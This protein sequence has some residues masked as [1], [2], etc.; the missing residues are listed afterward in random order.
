MGASNSLGIQMRTIPTSNRLLCI[1]QARAIAIAAMIIAHFAPGVVERL[2]M[3][4]LL[5]DFILSLGRIAT[6]GFAAIFGVTVGLVYLPKFLGAGGGAATKGLL[7]RAFMVTTCAFL[8]AIPRYA[9]QWPVPRMFNVSNLYSSYSVLLF[10]AIALLTMPIWLK[11]IARS[12]RAVSLTLAIISYMMV[13]IVR[14][15]AWPPSTDKDALEFV[16]LVFFSGKYA[17]FLMMGTTFLF[18]PI[19][20]YLHALTQ[21]RPVPAIPAAIGVLAGSVFVCSLVAP[22]FWVEDINEFV[23]Y[24]N[25]RTL[26]VWYHIA[27]GNLALLMIVAFDRL[28]RNSALWDVASHPLAV[29]GKQALPIYTAHAFILPSLHL[30]DRVYKIEGPLRAILPLLLFATICLL[31]VNR[32]DRTSGRKL[33]R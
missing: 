5:A 6:P 12:P 4:K 7:R 21:Q 11:L 18:I 13:G 30:T 15:R 32:S 10:Y 22:A 25:S 3:P 14:D 27:F 23:N 1:D 19:G 28:N 2:T 29:V 9:W 33:V 26:W 17:Y 24:W 8:V 20:L 31:I 16:R